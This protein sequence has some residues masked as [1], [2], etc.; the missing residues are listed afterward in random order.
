LPRIQDRITSQAI[1]QREIRRRADPNKE[2]SNLVLILYILYYQNTIIELHKYSPLL[3]FFD[4]K[5]F[6]SSDVI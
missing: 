1:N 2:Y 5:D 6:E 4:S 3:G